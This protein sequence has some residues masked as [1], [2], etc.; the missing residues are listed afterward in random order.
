VEKNKSN[1]SRR[2]FS[3][4]LSLG[5]LGTGLVIANGCSP[6]RQPSQTDLTSEAPQPKV[7]STAL[8]IWFA[9]PVA[10]PDV[11]IRQW[12]S[13]SE[14]PI[15]IQSIAIPELL[16]LDRC[17]ADVLLYPA[18]LLGELVQ[19]QWIDKLPSGLT[20][21]VNTPS[22]E[23]DAASDESSIPFPA[24]AL[25]AAKYL[26]TT[27]GLPLGFS[28]LAVLASSGTSAESRSWPQIKEELS[29]VQIKPVDDT[30]LDVDKSAM[31]DRFLNIAFGAS[32]TNPKY[33]LLFDSRSLKS[34]LNSPEFLLAAEILQ[35]LASQDEAA[36]SVVGSHTEAWKWINQP[37]SRGFA[38]VSP[39]QLD[40]A[41]VELDSAQLLKLPQSRPWN[42]GHG[43]VGSISTTCQQSAQS[44]KFIEW[45]SL[46]KTMEALKYQ[47]PA[48]GSVVSRGRNLVERTM[49]ALSAQLQDE[50][51]ISELRMPGVTQF[52]EILAE[53]LLQAL[54]AKLSCQQA[55]QQ[56]AQDWD[57]IVSKTPQF[58]QLYQQS[59]GLNS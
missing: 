3:R 2:T 46:Q 39:T 6:Q 44:S 42:S 58:K 49:S 38:I 27:W 41:S 10:Q 24:A 51:L 29:A 43:L 50:H 54:T 37:G 28:A 8:R 23:S 14:Q 48:M 17:A 30:R 55:L 59:L 9:A 33:G 25:A 52:Y 5:L 19:R 36:A 35:R 21:L 11:I 18:G 45:L 22:K 4:D 15:E 32:N 57:Q 20:K 26:G 34:R 7:T 31:L 47:V 40:A 16:K 53:K 12:N 56:A 1:P 13:S